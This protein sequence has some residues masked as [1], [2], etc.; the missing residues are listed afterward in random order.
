M[1]AMRAPLL[2]NKCREIIRRLLAGQRPEDDNVELKSEWPVGEK[3]PRAAKQIAGLANA[4]MGEPAIW[5]IGVREDPPSVVDANLS[6][7]S[8]WHNQIQG[9]FDGPMPNLRT[10]A[11]FDVDG[12]NVVALLFETDAAPYVVKLDGKKGKELEVPWRQGVST[13]SARR[14]EIISTLA[15]TVPLPECEVLDCVMNI[16]QDPTNNKPA[17]IFTA[18]VTLYLASRSETPIILPFHRSSVSFS[19]DG[20][21]A[22]TP[23]PVVRIV[24]AKRSIAAPAATVT[25][26]SAETLIRHAGMVK[27]EAH[28][29]VTGAP[30]SHLELGATLTLCVLFAPIELKRHFRMKPVL[31][32]AS[33]WRLAR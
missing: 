30:A 15:P 11:S 21:E 20:E 3:L 1:T 33:S 25:Q 5:L 27:V 7:L 24:A 13:R 32:S 8:D 22:D 28:I 9:H 18:T 31:G 16:G 26:S 12:V 19:V 14:S 23:M 6:E 29:P 4:A 10:T 17:S 2:E